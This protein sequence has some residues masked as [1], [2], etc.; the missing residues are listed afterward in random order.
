MFWFCQVVKVDSPT[1]SVESMPRISELL[2]R[3]VT[4]TKEWMENVQLLQA[5]QDST[6]LNMN[7]LEDFMEGRFELTLIYSLKI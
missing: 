5:V 2:R 7:I 3:N 4:P 1:W 6:L